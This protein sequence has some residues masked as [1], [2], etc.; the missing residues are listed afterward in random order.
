[1]VACSA[2]TNKQIEQKSF[3]IG[4]KYIAEVPI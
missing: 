3:S 2:Y 1:M 4:F